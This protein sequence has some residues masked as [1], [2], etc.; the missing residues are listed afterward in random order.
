MAS[1]SGSSKK[2]LKKNYVYTLVASLTALVL[3]V[4]IVISIYFI[5]T[6]P[7]KTVCEPCCPPCPDDSGPDGLMPIFCRTVYCNF[8]SRCTQLDIG[9]PS[10]LPGDQSADTWIISP[11]IQALANGPITFQEY[12]NNVV[13]SNEVTLNGQPENIKLTTYARFYEQQLTD[14]FLFRYENR[15]SSRLLIPSGRNTPDGYVLRVNTTD[16][17][18]TLT[19]GPDVFALFRV[20]FVFNQ[21]EPSNYSVPTSV[22]YEEG[23]VKLYTHAQSATLFTGYL[24]ILFPSDNLSFNWGDDEPRI[25][26]ISADVNGDYPLKTNNEYVDRAWFFIYNSVTGLN[27]LPNPIR[28]PDFDPVE[29]FQNCYESL[30]V[31]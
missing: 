11:F 24:M 20:G 3:L 30:E 31:N 2:Y 16:S 27:E 13:I 29:T 7:S 17:G 6:P 10:S 21:L 15:P 9:W 8:L 26:A 28:D 1:T 22:N 19:V 25:Y 5:L 14:D 18:L 23:R 12:P 4:G